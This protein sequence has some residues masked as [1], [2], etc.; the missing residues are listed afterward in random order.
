[1][2]NQLKSSVILLFFLGVLFSAPIVAVG[3]SVHGAELAM[4]GAL[5]GIVLVMMGPL[6]FFFASSLATNLELIL[7]FI[8]GAVFF[9]A[10]IRALAR[11]AEYYV[12]YLPV[13]GWALIGAYFCVSLFFA[14]ATT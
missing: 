2:N 9:I 3:Y 6:A 7:I 13:T 8:L 4:L 1:M 14:H 11:G 5:A 12:P 10:W